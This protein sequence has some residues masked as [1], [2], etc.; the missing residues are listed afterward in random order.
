MSKPWTCHEQFMNNSWTSD[1]KV[2]N[3]SR[4]LSHEPAMNNLW[5]SPEQVMRK[6]LRSHKKAIE[7]YM[8]KPWTSQELAMSKSWTCQGQ[9][10]SKS[11]A[12]Y[13]QVRNKLWTSQDH[14]HINQNVKP[15]TFFHKEKTLK[16]SWTKCLWFN[17]S[18]TY[19]DF[20]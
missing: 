3:K 7:N 11:W 13:E 18:S 4:L 14:G 10:M 2:M 19:E 1:E 6:S 15:K 8:R 17:T 5:T 12:S 20:F 16:P 9:A